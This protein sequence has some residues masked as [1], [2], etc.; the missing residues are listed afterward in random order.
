MSLVTCKERLYLFLHFSETNYICGEF[1]WRRLDV[2]FN[3]IWERLSYSWPT[4]WAPRGKDRSALGAQV[5]VIQ[6]WLEEVEP[7]CTSLRPH[8][9]ADC[10]WGRSSFW[11]SLLGAAFSHEPGI[12]WYGRAIFFL[13]LRHL[14][15]VP[16][17]LLSHLCCNAF[18]VVSICPVAVDVQ[19]S[20]VWE[21]LFDYL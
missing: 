14:C 13:P 11:R 8:L 12:F 17:L 20:S 6:L 5:R 2:I 3:V 16:V 1:L 10:Y 21:Y 19:S 4:D 18:L 9:R 7:G 15:I